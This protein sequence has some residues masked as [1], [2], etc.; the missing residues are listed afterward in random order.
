[1]ISELKMHLD[2]DDGNPV[3]VGRLSSSGTTWSL[4]A[5]ALP[6]PPL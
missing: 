2:L 4:P 3:E 6:Q 5:P 1:M